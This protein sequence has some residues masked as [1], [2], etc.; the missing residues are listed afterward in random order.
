MKWKLEW[1]EGYDGY[2]GREILFTFLWDKDVV[3]N[4]WH[5][6]EGILIEE[7]SLS[8]RIVS[9]F[10]SIEIGDN[11]LDYENTCNPAISFEE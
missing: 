11:L 5:E 3:F 1:F 10:M 4:L 7:E 8:F 9:N 6:N 2:L